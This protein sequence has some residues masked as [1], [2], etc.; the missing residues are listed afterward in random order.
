MSGIYFYGSGQRSQ[1]VCGC[2]ARGLQIA[3]VDRMR[4]DG[5]IIPRQSFVGEPI[6]RVEMRLQ[7]RVPLGGTRLDRR[8]R[9][10]VQSVQ[11]RQLRRLQPDGDEPDV[12]TADREPESVVRR[13]H[14]AIGV[15][16]PVLQTSSRPR[17]VY[18]AFFA[19]G[20][21][22]LIYQVV[23]VRAFGNVFGNTIHSASLVVAVFMLGLGVGSR[24][25]GAWADR[26]YA[27]APG[28]LLRVVRP[29]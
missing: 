6:H 8:L 21:S 10:S 24:V 22:G 2:D 27:R 25:I 20:V 28:S 18:L 5:T 29:R 9:R 17:L 4:L 3:S 15:Q 14:S 26:R 1:V 16:V 19:S 13:S 12:R 11:Q 23:W 7:Q